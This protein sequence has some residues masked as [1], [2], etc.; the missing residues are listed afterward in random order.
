MTAPPVALLLARLLT[1]YLATPAFVVAADGAVAFCNEAAEEL[2]GTTFP[3]LGRVP[4]AEL[5]GLLGT[6]ASEETALAA[7]LGADRP[8]QLALSIAPR[9]RPRQEAA[10]TAFPMLAPGRGPVGTVAFLWL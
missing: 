1:S 8:R 5:L 3:E 4:A 7:A 9:G 2:L 6:E 10:L